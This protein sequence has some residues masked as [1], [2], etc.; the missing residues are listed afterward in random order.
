MDILESSNSSI[1]VNPPDRCNEIGGTLETPEPA[2]PV[3]WEDVEPRLTGHSCM[4][5]HLVRYQPSVCFVS[6]KGG[7]GG[8]GQTRYNHNK[9]VCVVL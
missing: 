4:Y 7:G 6:I 5:I 1:S 8:G 9:N 2:G 3:E